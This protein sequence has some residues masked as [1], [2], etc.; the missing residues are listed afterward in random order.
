MPSLTT[1][2]PLGFGLPALL[3]VSS[4]ALLPWPVSAARAEEPPAAAGRK[5]ARVYTND[6]LDR[7]RRFRDETGVRSVPA[8]PA[9]ERP[10]VRAA[11]ERPRSRG[12]DY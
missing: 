8:V 10:T 7:V 5:P 9:G 4:A 1:H 3:L 6:D 12:E 11:D 2:L